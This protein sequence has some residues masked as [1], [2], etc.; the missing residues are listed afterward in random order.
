MKK[1]GNVEVY[2]GPQELNQPDALGE[3]I[4]NFIKK[5][6]KALFIAVQELDSASIAK[7]IIEA[8][9]RG[10][11][12][13]LIMEADY[14]TVQKPLN[15]PWQ[16]TGKNEKNR[17]IHNALM[18]A[19]VDVKT[20]YN[21]KIFHQKFIVRDPL[22]AQA[23][24]LTGSTNFT[25]TG[26]HSNLNHIVI[27]RGKRHAQIY[28]DEF[29][30]MATGTFGRLRLRFDAPPK[31]YSVSGVRIKTLF[32]PDHSPEM[33]IMK[34]MLK[35]KEQIDF[36]IFTFAKSSGIDDTMVSLQK[37][38]I[39]VRG[40]FDP[41]QG[42]QKWAAT[43]VLASNKIKVY[44]A[45]KSP[46]LNKLHHKLMVIDKQVVIAGSF[47]YTDPANTLNDENIIIIGDLDEKRKNSIKRQKQIGQYVYGWIDKMVKDNGKLISKP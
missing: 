38:G 41:G 3:V 9:S 4:I 45:K 47:N 37:S 26:T 32:A 36:A 22:G 23:A 14:L 29:K 13:S 5:A 35:A 40:I 8:K 27:I 28:L 18:R 42:N 43:R 21:P 24:V 2:M 1:I 39:K 15:D 46:Q 17:E 10:I 12:V 16:L 44:L 34:Q 25:D 11:S 20:D 33:E 6:K 7:A 30:E 19:K 31:T